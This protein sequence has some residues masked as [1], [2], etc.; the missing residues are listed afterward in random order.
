MCDV[1]HN[2]CGSDLLHML[3]MLMVSSN[4]AHVGLC[5]D[6][7]LWSKRYRVSSFWM[8]LYQQCLIYL[9]HWCGTWLGCAL[10]RLAG[11]NDVVATHVA[12]F[13]TAPT[14][15]NDALWMCI[16]CIDGYPFHSRCVVS[17][18]LIVLHRSLIVLHR[19]GHHI[20]LSLLLLHSCNDFFFLGYKGL[21]EMYILHWQS[22][23]S[24]TIIT[25]MN[26]SPSKK[27]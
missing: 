8:P 17:F 10:C 14:C 12:C 2:L 5:F 6:L 19:S 13:V 11:L 21:Q 25:V 3:D 16:V 22:A 26:I 23:D 18:S 7:T 4:I 1:V 9:A 20:S 24:T 27:K 15:S